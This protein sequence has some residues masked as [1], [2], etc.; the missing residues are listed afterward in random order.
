MN[1]SLTECIALQKAAGTGEHPKEGSCFPRKGCV[2]EE[3]DFGQ[4]QLTLLIWHQLFTSAQ[5]RA[6]ADAIHSRAATSL[7]PENSYCTQKKQKMEDGVNV[8][9]GMEAGTSLK[10]ARAAQQDEGM[11]STPQG[12]WKK[13]NGDCYRAHVGYG[14]SWLRNC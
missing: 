8:V 14:G 2:A 6:G 12:T 10:E 5:G 11:T 1:P 7:G 3:E 4:L 9:T 13:V